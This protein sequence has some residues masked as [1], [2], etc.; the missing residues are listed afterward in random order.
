[1]IMFRQDHERLSTY[2]CASHCTTNDSM[3]QAAAN[4]RVGYIHTNA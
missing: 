2:K 4:P 3:T 1:M